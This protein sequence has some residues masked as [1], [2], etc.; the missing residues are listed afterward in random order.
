MTKREFN[1]Y[2]DRLISKMNEGVETL[3]NVQQMLNETTEDDNCLINPQSTRLIEYSVSHTISG[4]S[5]VVAEVGFND[6]NGLPIFQPESDEH[7]R[8]RERHLMERITILPS[9]SKQKKATVK[10]A[11]SRKTTKK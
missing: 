5:K 7:R 10:K 1:R 3:N 11:T 9:P 2:L 4:L 6:V 8:Q